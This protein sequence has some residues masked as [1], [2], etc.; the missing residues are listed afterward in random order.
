ML[1]RSPGQ[2]PTVDYRPLV[3]AWL[4]RHKRY[5][6]SA[7]ERGEEGSVA[8]RFRVDHY[9]RV[10][11]YALLNST[12]YADL[13]RSVEQMMNGAQLPPFPPGMT[14]PDIELSVGLRFILTQ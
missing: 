2:D 4:E 10:I 12:G 3:S 1:F 5:P 14:V 11:D 13:D 8:L 6:D 7:R 9:G